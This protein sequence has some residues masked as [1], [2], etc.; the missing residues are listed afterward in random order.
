VHLHHEPKFG[1]TP[2]SSHRYPTF[3]Q[4]FRGISGP[5]P[6]LGTCCRILIRASARGKQHVGPFQCD[7][8]A[9]LGHLGEIGCRQQLL[10]GFAV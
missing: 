5:S 7:E 2:D 10:V 3:A 6:G 9:G 1:L 8:V 4:L